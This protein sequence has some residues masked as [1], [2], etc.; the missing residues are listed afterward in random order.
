MLAA[1]LSSLVQKLEP[2]AL[3]DLGLA[4]FAVAAL[5]TNPHHSFSEQPCAF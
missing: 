2:E 1:H 4:P 5:Y 3:P